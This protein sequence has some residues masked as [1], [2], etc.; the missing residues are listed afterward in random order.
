MKKA[1]FL[2]RD[3]VINSSAVVDGKP[4][5][6]KNLEELKILP[7]VEAALVMLRESGYLCIVIT[8]QPDVARGKVTMESVEE[9]NNHLRERLAIDDIYACYHDDEDKCE[10]RKPKPG[11]ILGASQMYNI[12][13]NESYMIGDR[14][15]DIEAGQSAGCKT[16]F[17]DY[18]YDEKRPVG[19]TYTAGS[20]LDAVKLILRDKN[21][22]N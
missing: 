1:I 21:E 3:G 20:L 10:C 15:R 6:P 17:I 16:V 2:D 7:G 18:S 19:H 13:L 4:H 5:T 8:N 11:A 14:W 12:N 22:K 9:L